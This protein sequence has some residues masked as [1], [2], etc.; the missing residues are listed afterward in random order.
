MK[1]FLLLLMTVLG[2]FASGCSNEDNG[3]QIV[4]P[5]PE[6]K[7]IYVT[8]SDV[9]LFQSPGYIT[10]FEGLPQGDISY[11]TSNALQ[12]KNSYG[13][14]TYGKWIFD[15]ANAAGDAGLQKYAV[16][17]N[18]SLQ[19]EGFIVDAS[20]YLVVD[21]TTGYYLDENRGTH[22]IQKFNPGTMQRTGEIDLG[23][24]K[25]GE[26]EYEVIGKHVLAAKEGKLYASISY[27]TNAAQGY[28]DDQVD[29]VQ[30]AVVDMATG[31]LDKTIK[32]EDLKGIGW[33]SSANRMWKMGDDGA[34]Y[35]CSTGLGNTAFEKSSVIRIKKGETDFDK[36]WIFKAYE[37]QPGA[38]VSTVFVK[39]GKLYVELPN[40]PLKGDY[41]NLSDSY[42]T[43]AKWDYYV[44]DMSTG[45]VTKISGMPTHHYCYFSD[46]AITEIDGELYFWVKNKD[47]KIDGYY[48]LNEDGTSATQVF[49]NTHDGY[50]WG[51]AKLQ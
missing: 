26:Y 47:E 22:K 6:E 38:S 11:T 49:N 7:D 50:T 42:G 33:G 24:L 40:E 41:S 18:G 17:E 30:F 15:R 48:V 31:Q 39:G 13:F 8:T 16:S 19:D 14:R 36:S 1:Q 21:E 20:Q 32:F 46:Q 25:T 5:E 37:V 12:V 23:S 4:D 9:A 3:D 27:G 34:L 35:F 2:L 43:G 10:P 29:Y 28:G 45:E 44:V 51:F